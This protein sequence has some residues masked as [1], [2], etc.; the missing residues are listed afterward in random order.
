MIPFLL[1]LN[2]ETVQQ[3]LLLSCRDQLNWGTTYDPA[4]TK[5][6]YP[7]GDVDKTKGVCSDVVIRAYRSVG[8]DLQKE[9]AVHKKAN[10]KLYP[11]SKIDTNIDHRRVR[12]LAIYFRAKKADLTLDKDWRPGDIIYWKLIDNRDH[13]GI[14]SDQK[15]MKGTYK[16]FHNINIPREEDCFDRWRIVG[17]YRFI[18]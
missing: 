1:L 17:H 16:V 10:P 15:G 6:K 11:E 4:Y 9:L 14:L 12:N 5:L 2:P 3:K 18:K 8:I 7:G 13:I